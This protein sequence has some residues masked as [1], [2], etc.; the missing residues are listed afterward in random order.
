MIRGGVFIFMGKDSSEPI[1]AKSEPKESLL[2]H[3]KNCI[4]VY[5]SIR[6][7]MPF[8]GDTSGN[9]DFFEH[10]YYAVALHDLGKAAE[11]F[12]D[13]L[14]PNGRRWNY[15]HEILSAGF[16]VGVQLPDIAKQAIGLSVL[17]H[18]KDIKTLR[19]NYPCFP[20][21]NPGFAT[22][23]KKVKE[24][25]ANWEQIIQIQNYIIKMC[26]ENECRFEPV[27]DTGEVINAYE[28][29]LLPYYKNIENGD[30]TDLRNN[31]GMLMRGCLI[32]CDHLASDSSG[33]NKIIC[34]LENLDGA[35]KSNIRDRNIKWNSVQKS[36]MDTHGN[37]ML[38]APTGSGKTEASMLWS[39]INQ[40]KTNGKRVFYVLPY[41]ASINAMYKRLKGVLTGERVC[42][43]HGKAS[44]FHYRSL[45]NWEDDYFTRQTTVK[46]I[47]SLS[48]K[49]YRPYKVLTPF[50]LLKSFFGIKGFEMQ[51]AEMSNGLFI[52][53]EIHAY[54]E[55]TTALIIK[56]IEKL[57]KDYNAKICVM[58]ATMPKF[59]K[60]KIEDVFCRADYNDVAMPSDERNK[61]YTRH[62][63]KMLGDNMLGVIPHIKE[64]LE[65]GRKVMVVCNTVKKSQEVYKELQDD[66][67]KSVLI[68]SRFILKDRERI[69]ANLKDV[70]LIVGTQAVEVSLD[71]DF[72]VLFTEPAPLDSLIQRFGRIN[73]KNKKGICNVFICKIGGKSDRY[74]Y[75]Q[76]IVDK[77]VE[78]LVNIDILYE[79]EIQG[80]I[81]TVYGQGYTEVQE[82]KYNYI[83]DTFETHLNS[84]NPFI[85]NPESEQEFEGLFKSVEVVPEQFQN[86]Y[87]ECVDQKKYYESMSYITQIS[88]RRFQRLKKEKLINIIDGNCIVNVGY[89][90]KLGLLVEKENHPYK[91]F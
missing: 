85:E 60:D 22:Y 50:Q 14:K 84:L 43:L 73:R 89:D 75:S 71:I 18:H 51:F 31:Y 39:S 65:R 28:S 49:I 16:T 34:A 91:E 72:D 63:V 87:L 47:Q 6:D 54:D 42:M 44:Y 58:T 19:S 64:E 61:S 7:R 66:K 62:K 40:N 12:Q 88:Q 74:I 24:M 57:Y 56:M 32:A 30:S 3:T 4:E 37:L 46:K 86:E 17:T 70:D 69:E 78:V 53:D 67:T 5:L 23:Q 77:T 27:E 29:Y 13:Q 90:E 55:H 11:G 1:L 8:L 45:A 76:K 26:P 38:S 41:T 15:R 79:S 36:S 48:R 35:L 52:F 20:E 68:H 81:D 25:K 10:L 82:E 9:S 59:L 80:L 83:R 21:R 33:E 2:D